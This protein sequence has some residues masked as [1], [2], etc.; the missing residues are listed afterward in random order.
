MDFRKIGKHAVNDFKFCD[1]DFIIANYKNVVLL[2]NLTDQINIGSIIR[3]AAICGF[4]VMLREKSTINDFTLKCASGGVNYT[5]ICKVKN[6][7]ETLK[8]LKQN[9]F[10]IIGLSEK[11][12]V[13]KP[14]GFDKKVLVVGSEGDGISMLVKNNCDIL[15]RLKG[16]K[17]FDVY[18]AS[19]AAA[20]AMYVQMTE[21]V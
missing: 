20:I 12:S 21:D 6:I 16:N 9:G 3:T 13:E 18:N 11:G 1:L 10:W 15:W 2:D 7:Q 5:S 19:N 14:S 4:A 17:N 8:K